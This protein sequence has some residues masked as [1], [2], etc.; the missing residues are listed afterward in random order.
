MVRRCHERRS[1]WDPLFW[2]PIAAILLHSPPSSFTLV[3]YTGV[4]KNINE[5]GQ[6]N[7][8]YF[9]ILRNHARPDISMVGEEEREC[10]CNLEGEK[11]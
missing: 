4:L 1:S 3:G 7:C 9:S 2:A 10:L 5:I 8:F 11:T 6:L